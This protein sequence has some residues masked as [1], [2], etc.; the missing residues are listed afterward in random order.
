MPFTSPRANAVH[1]IARF[2]LGRYPTQSQ[3]VG[4]YRKLIKRESS[5]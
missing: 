2:M 1:T 4:I 3:L 5:C